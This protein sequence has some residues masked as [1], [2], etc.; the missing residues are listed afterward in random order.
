MINQTKNSQFTTRVLIIGLV[1][2]ILILVSLVCI[3]AV[4][5][6]YLDRNFGSSYYAPNG[7]L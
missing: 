4:Q 3:G 6:I 1:G 7:L 5:M 2:I